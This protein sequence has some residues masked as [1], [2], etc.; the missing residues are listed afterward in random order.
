MGAMLGTGPHSLSAWGCP[1]PTQGKAFHCPGQP[2]Q[3]GRLEKTP[4][5]RDTY[6]G[7]DTGFPASV[8]SYSNVTHSGAP[9]P[10][11]SSAPQNS[12]SSK[13]LIYYSSLKAK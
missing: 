7:G 3:T 10:H 2:R 6:T 1:F 5:R 4:Q 11:A 9:G 12:P 8:P 13:D